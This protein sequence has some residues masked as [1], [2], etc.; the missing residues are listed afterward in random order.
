MIL[1]IKTD[2]PEAMLALWRDNTEVQKISWHAHRELSSTILINLEQ[3]LS[4]NKL[5]SADLEGIVFF[6]G[7][8]S[9]TGLRIGCSLANSLAYA[10]EI[11]VMATHGSSWIQEGIKALRNGHG[12]PVVRPDYGR[13]AR[14]TQPRK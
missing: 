4:D 1:T 14:I 6:A 12:Q 10:H 5:A 8:G 9:F 7:P 11:P 13:P 3:L 2:Q